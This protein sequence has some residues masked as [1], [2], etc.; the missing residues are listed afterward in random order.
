M[1]FYAEG[2]GFVTRRSFVLCGLK[3]PGR[4]FIVTME[5]V[6]GFF[7]LRSEL[8][9]MHRQTEAEAV[10]KLRARYVWQWAQQAGGWAQPRR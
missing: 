6:I 5:Y 10:L 8:H 4:L 2:I 3:Q 7:V 9:R 1:S